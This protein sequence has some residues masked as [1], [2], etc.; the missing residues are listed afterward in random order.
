MRA[1]NPQSPFSHPSSPSPWR[2]GRTTPNPHSHIPL[3]PLPGGEG[4]QPPIPILTSLFPLSLEER[5]NN[6]QSPFSHPSSPSPWRRGRTTPNPRSH[7]PLLPLPGGEGEQPP[8]P[9]LTSLFSLSLGERAGVRANHPPFPFSD[10]MA[11]HSSSLFPRLNVPA[12]TPRRSGWSPGKTRAPL[13]A[14]A[15]P[16]PPPSLSCPCRAR[17]TG[18]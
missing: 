2:R 18:R 11:L 7:I 4:E 8:I 1:N 6:P 14:P 9:I 15:T 3:L 5:A 16:L 13:P 12:T 10:S 17:H